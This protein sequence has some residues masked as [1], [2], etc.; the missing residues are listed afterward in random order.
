MNLWEIQSFVGNLLSASPKLAGVPVLKDDGTYPKTPEREKALNE[1]GLLL[2]VWEIESD[3]LADQSI[4]GVAAH[5]IYVPVVIE[6]NVKINRAEGGTGIEATQALQFVLEA[7]SGKPRP[8]LP[9]RGL[10]LMDPPFRNFGKINGINRMVVNF[11]LRAF[12]A[13]Q[14]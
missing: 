6:E 12:V 14:S 13:P 4:T 3:G 2:I 1:K 7:C 5:D 11:S 9:N 10:V 8:S